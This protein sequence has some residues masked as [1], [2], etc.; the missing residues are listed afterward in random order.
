MAEDE[1]R[2][3]LLWLEPAELCELGALALA[4]AEL[5]YMD[6]VNAPTPI[7]DQVATLIERAD[8][9]RM[10]AAQLAGIF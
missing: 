2:A 5:G 3:L 8:A 6:L 9:R 7:Q 10:A 1:W 4:A